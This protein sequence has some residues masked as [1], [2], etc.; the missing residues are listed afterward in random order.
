LFGGGGNFRLDI[1]FPLGIIATFFFSLVALL[2]TIQKRLQ[3][4][5]SHL[6]LE[7]VLGT[8]ACCML[9][10]DS[11]QHAKP[12]TAERLLESGAWLNV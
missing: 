9:T 7:P 3:A 12:L 4:R 8:V 1:A 5:A 10:L 11:H 2:L 6:L